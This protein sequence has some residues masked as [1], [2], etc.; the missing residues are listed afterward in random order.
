MV[1]NGYASSPF[2]RATPRLGILTGVSNV[3]ISQII[4]LSIPSFMCS[5]SLFELENLMSQSLQPELPPLK[6]PTLQTLQHLI[7]KH[8]LNYL[9]IHLSQTQKLRTFVLVAL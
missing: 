5:G 9:I 8:T 3:T 6:I 1:F 4:Y 7:L 2:L